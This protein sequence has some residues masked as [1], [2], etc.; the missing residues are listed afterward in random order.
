MPHVLALAPLQPKTKGF[1]MVVDV[2]V[3]TT[4]WVN[5]SIYAPQPGSLHIQALGWNIMQRLPLVD[6]LRAK[7]I[8]RRPSGPC[9]A[10]SCRV[11]R[12]VPWPRRAYTF[13]PP[14]RWEQKVGSQEIRSL[15][16]WSFL[17]YIRFPLSLNGSRSS[18][19]FKGSHHF[20]FIGIA[21]CL[22]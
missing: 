18:N 12:L 9:P 16:P 13:K 20:F 17:F 3:G 21:P 11:W 10:R 5:R 7:Q 19:V 15:G 1:L 2:V 6:V 8:P 14:N 22:F 4:C